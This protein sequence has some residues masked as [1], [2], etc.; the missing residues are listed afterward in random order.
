M[1]IQSSLYSGISGL[2]T[3]GNAMSVIGN[4][5]ANTNTIGFK[6]SRTVFSDLLSST[7]SG[8]S[9]TS[10]VGRGVQLSSVDN[11]FS[12]GTFENTESNSDLA[13]EGAGFFMVRPSDG[14]TIQYTRAGAFHFNDVGS[15]VNSEGSFCQ[16]YYLDNNGNT[17][18]DITDITVNT[19]TFTP[20]TP[21]SLVDLST[22]LNSSSPYLGGFDITSPANTSNYATSLQVFDSMGET[23]LLTNYFVKRDPTI[24]PRTWDVYTVVDSTELTTPGPDSLTQVGTGTLVFDTSGNLT[25]PVT[26]TTNAG[27]LDWVNGAAQAQQIA[28]NMLTTQ[29][30]SDS[31]I[32]SQSQNG[33]AP[34]TLTKLEIDSDGIITGFYSNG[35]PRQ[36]AQ[37]ALAS[38]NNP[39]GLTKR[40]NNLYSESTVSGPPSIGT[41]GSYVGKIF[42]NSLEHSNVDLAQE[43]VKMITIQRGFQANSK[44]ITTTDEMLNDLINLKR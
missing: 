6:A 33:Y 10:Q 22:N 3:N 30:A 27:D 21:T 24:D 16:G 7:V 23:H 32:N 28:F 44:I 34:G 19:S 43:F 17:V 2:A 38:F 29:Y 36:L 1:S 4:N 12:Q 8:S 5:I 26:I 39:G 42:T 37:I 20:A 40:G 41:V 13:I 31:L 11:I 25:T 18:G 9:G 14:T 15:L 35:E